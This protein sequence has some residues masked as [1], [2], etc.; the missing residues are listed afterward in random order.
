[1]QS[2]YLNGT[3]CNSSPPSQNY[4]ALSV[5]WELWSKVASKATTRRLS[6][7]ETES[8]IEALY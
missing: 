4:E 8:P 6:R 5:N 3:T 1:M 7:E 2:K